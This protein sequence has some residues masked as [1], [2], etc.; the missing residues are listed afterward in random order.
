MGSKTRKRSEKEQLA[1]DLAE[2]D[3]ALATKFQSDPDFASWASGHRGFAR[4]V[5]REEKRSR[6]RSHRTAP[7]DEAIAHSSVIPGRRVAED[8]LIDL[9][10]GLPDDCE[11]EDERPRTREKKP[12]TKTA[13][14]SRSTKGTASYVA[15][16]RFTRHGAGLAAVT[17][18]PTSELLETVRDVADPVL[19]RRLL[20]E[21]ASTVD[22]PDA[23][24]WKQAEHAL[25]TAELAQGAIALY[26]AIRKAFSSRA[27]LEDALTRLPTERGIPVPEPFRYLFKSVS[28]LG[29]GV[30]RIPIVSPERGTVRSQADNSPSVGSTRRVELFMGARWLKSWVRGDQSESVRIDVCAH[31]YMDVLYRRP[32]GPVKAAHALVGDIV[33]R[34]ASG[35][36]KVCRKVKNARSLYSS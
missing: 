21:L 36:A 16:P 31:E 4:S 12:L 30:R 14:R 10:D 15:D 1:L 11:T 26:K 18:A 17:V 3:Q 23:L 8:P 33:G 22:A 5:R 32:G 35:V 24:A 34:T 29:P 9:I 20:D 7:Y 19:Q 28:A 2:G 13:R 6:A 25:V 27:S